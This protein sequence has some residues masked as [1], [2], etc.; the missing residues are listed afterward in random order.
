MASPRQAIASEL[1]SCSR[2]SPPFVHLLLPE[3]DFF[4][5]GG[6]GLSG[7]ISPAAPR[8]LVWAIHVIASAG[9][10]KI[11]EEIYILLHVEVV[12]RSAPVWAVRTTRC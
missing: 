1:D 6:G 12:Q 2:K 8:A 4:L 5:G 10:A 9:G 7:F 11:N 3:P